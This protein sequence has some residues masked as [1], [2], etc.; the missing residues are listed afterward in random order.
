SVEVGLARRFEQG[1][2][3][4]LRGG[5]TVY[6]ALSPLG[7]LSYNLRDARSPCTHQHQHFN[8]LTLQHFN[9][10]TQ[11]KGTSSVPLPVQVIG[12]NAGQGCVAAFISILRFASRENLPAPNT[13]K[14]IRPTKTKIDISSSMRFPTER[15]P[16]G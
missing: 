1:L 13:I 2:T 8:T 6:Q 9:T 11:E 15:K 4:L 16:S 14:R 5:F 12:K 7:D 3:R 10:L